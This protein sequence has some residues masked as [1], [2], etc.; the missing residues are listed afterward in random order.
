MRDFISRHT[1]EANV[2]T[3][4]DTVPT[5]QD[6]NDATEKWWGRWGRQQRG[7]AT[8]YLHGREGEGERFFFGESVPG[9]ST[10]SAWVLCIYIIG[11]AISYFQI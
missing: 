11:L 6:Q 3:Q 5:A 1:S 8:M 7:R 10:P 4:G 9:E 2:N